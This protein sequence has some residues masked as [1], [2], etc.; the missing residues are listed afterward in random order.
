MFLVGVV[1]AGF[2]VVEGWAA[3]GL[4]PGDI[5]LGAAAFDDIGFGQETAV[6]GTN[7]EG[8]VGPVANEF[9]VEP[10]VFNHE[11]SDA[12]GQGAVGAGADP[13]PDVG[14]VG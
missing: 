2:G 12:E 6:V 8:A 3:G 9:P 1:T 4:V 13:E 11:M 14:P 10:A 5:A 7:E